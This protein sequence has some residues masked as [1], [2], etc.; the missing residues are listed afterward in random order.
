MY[1]LLLSQIEICFHAEEFY[2]DELHQHA[3]KNSDQEFI[4]VCYSFTK[5]CTLDKL[6]IN[7]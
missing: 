3:Y 6:T 5:H 1:I 7:S 4:L 2:D